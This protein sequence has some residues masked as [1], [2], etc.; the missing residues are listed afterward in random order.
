MYDDVRMMLPLVGN[1]ALLAVTV[2]LFIA[3]VSLERRAR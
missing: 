3:T 1:C 2:A